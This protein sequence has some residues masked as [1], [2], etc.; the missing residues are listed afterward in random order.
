MEHE[1]VQPDEIVASEVGG[2]AVKTGAT[3]VK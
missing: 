2:E 1:F 3:H